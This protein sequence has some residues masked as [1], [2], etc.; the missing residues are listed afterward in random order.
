[1]RGITVRFCFFCLPLVCSSC[2]C[3]AAAFAGGST[4]GN[5]IKL[6]NSIFAYNTVCFLCLFDCVCLCRL[7]IFTTRI[8]A[9]RNILMAGATTNGLYVRVSLFFLYFSSLSSFCVVCV[10]SRH[11]AVARRSC[12]QPPRSTSTLSSA[13]RKPTAKSVHC[14]QAR[15]LPTAKA[16]RCV[17]ACV[18]C[19]ILCVDVIFSFC[20]CLVLHAS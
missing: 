1:M 14:L 7:V 12:A 16:L 10:N 18:C 5:N 17:C 15:Q 6:S 13:T 19:C 4:G 20:C 11:T 3:V 9:T 2:C 8:P